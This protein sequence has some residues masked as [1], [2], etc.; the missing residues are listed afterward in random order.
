MAP[1]K[2]RSQHLSFSWDQQKADLIEHLAISM[3]F[4]LDPKEAGI[5]SINKF[6]S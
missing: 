5:I 3:T 1:I 2:Y 4:Q 6:V